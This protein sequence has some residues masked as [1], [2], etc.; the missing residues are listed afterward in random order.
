MINRA[1]KQ[2]NLEIIY[3]QRKFIAKE[4]RRELEEERSAKTTLKEKL[5]TTESQLRQTRMRVSKMDRQLREAEASIASLT[6]TVKS[7]EDQVS[8]VLSKN[9]NMILLYHIQF[10]K[11]VSFD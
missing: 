11:L 6:G 10:L 9:I 3:N 5:A 1:L 8:V 4:T 2:F 7:L